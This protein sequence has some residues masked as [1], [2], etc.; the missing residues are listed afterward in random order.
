MDQVGQQRGHGRWF[1][2]R[3]RIGGLD[4]NLFAQPDLAWLG[5]VTADEARVWW[6]IGKGWVGNL[7][8]V[9]QGTQRVLKV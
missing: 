1:S 7:N 8:K 2:L 6:N 3:A 9:G 4:W 5:W